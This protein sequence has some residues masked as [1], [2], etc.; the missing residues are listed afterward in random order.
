MNNDEPAEKHWILLLLHLHMHCLQLEEIN[1]VSL[2]KLCVNEQHRLNCSLPIENKRPT[3]DAFLCRT[4]DYQ[5]YRM[6]HMETRTFSML[7]IKVEKA[8]GRDMFK[9]EY[10]L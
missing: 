8:V 3:W 1:I 9:S 6:F 2:L 4:N 10:K 5:F 7:C